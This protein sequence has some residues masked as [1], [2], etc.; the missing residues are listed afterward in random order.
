MLAS[1]EAIL[2]VRNVRIMKTLFLTF[3]D[4][5][6]EFKAAATRLV[7]QAK[8]IGV[9][10]SVLSL[11]HKSL[12]QVSPEYSIAQKSIMQLHSY[13]TYFRAAKSWVIQAGL[14]GR[15]GEFDLVC[16]ADAGCEM[17]ANRITRQVLRNNLKKA[18]L[19]GGLAEQLPLTERNW[20]KKKTMDYFQPSDSHALSGQIQSGLSYWRVDEKNIELVSKWCSL[21]DPKLDLWQDPPSKDSEA[22]YFIEHRH[23]QSLFS[24]LWKEAGL[25]VVPVNSHWLLRLPN[26]RSACIPIHTSRNRTGATRLTRSSRSSLVATLGLGINIFGRI[27]NKGIKIVLKRAKKNP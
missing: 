1:C 15:F 3:G 9:F 4:G 26:T 11:D 17:V 19:Y 22:D 18:F 5:S 27:T 20:T 10:S 23:D 13:P 21:S 24:L 7:E 8:S 6:P 2:K 16:Y 12:I 14:L 25:L